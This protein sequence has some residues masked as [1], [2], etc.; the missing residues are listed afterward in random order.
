VAKAEDR[1]LAYVVERIL[2]A[3]FEK[4]PEPS[5]PPE[6][7]VTADARRTPATSRLAAFLVA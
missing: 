6:G 3:S 7:L 2:R 4:A 5:R 1:S